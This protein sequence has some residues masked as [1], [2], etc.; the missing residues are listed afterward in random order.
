VNNRP[1]YDVAAL[2]G[3]TLAAVI[4]TFMPKGPYSYLSVIVGITLLAIIYAFEHARNRTRSQ[5]FAVA[6]VCAL[7]G[8]LII[9]LC[10][11]LYIGGGKPIGTGGNDPDSAVNTNH[12]LISWPVQVVLFSL[13]DRYWLQPKATG[14]DT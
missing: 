11:E 12:L 2:P 10:A 6:C 7:S 13:Y 8:L 3:A 5:T 14:Y 9:G 1:N 4:A